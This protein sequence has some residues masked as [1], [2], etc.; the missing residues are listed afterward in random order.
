M[1]IGI[2]KWKL[3][4]LLNVPLEIGFGGLKSLIKIL[5]LIINLSLYEGKLIMCNFGFYNEVK[6]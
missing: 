3:L 2:G 5:C 6:H 4:L 1:I